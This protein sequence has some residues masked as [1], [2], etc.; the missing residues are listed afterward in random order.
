M[1]F[2]F[3]HVALEAKFLNKDE[4]KTDPE[5]QTNHCF[6]R[7]PET[8]C[9]FFFSCLPGNFPLKHGG[10]FCEISIVSVSDETKHKN[11]SKTFGENSE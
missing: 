9:D 2:L 1:L 4:D 11:S 5:S 10:D 6:A 3:G 8:F 7:S